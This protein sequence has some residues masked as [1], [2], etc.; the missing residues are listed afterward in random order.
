[1]PRWN[2]TASPCPMTIS[3]S[4]RFTFSWQSTTPLSEAVLADR[5]RLRRRRL[6]GAD[7]TY[8]SRK[9]EGQFN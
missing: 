1:M 2:A 6:S 4:Q 7:G 3:A 5:M 8:G 9:K